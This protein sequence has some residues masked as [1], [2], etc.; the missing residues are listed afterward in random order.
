MPGGGHDGS[1]QRVG[2]FFAFHFGVAV[3]DHVA[4]IREHFGGAIAAAW[5]AEQLG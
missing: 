2:N 4:K 3:E 1:F 5:K